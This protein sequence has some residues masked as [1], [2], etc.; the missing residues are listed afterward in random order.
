MD[1]RKRGA[2]EKGMPIRVNVVKNK[3]ASPFR[4]AELYMDFENGGLL[5]K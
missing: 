2:N 3:C 1:L 4:T 5:E